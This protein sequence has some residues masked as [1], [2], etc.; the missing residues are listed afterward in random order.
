M[1]RVTARIKTVTVVS[2]ALHAGWLDTIPQL[3][4]WCQPRRIPYVRL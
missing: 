4:G 2:A 3:D 1:G